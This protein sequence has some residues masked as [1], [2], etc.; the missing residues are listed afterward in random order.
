RV[1][2]RKGDK[3]L[4]K[5][6]ADRVGVAAASRTDN[7]QAKRA[8]L[9][10]QLSAARECGDELLAKARYAIQERPQVAVWNA[11]HTRCAPRNGSHNY[12]S[13]SQQ[14]DVARKLARAVTD[15]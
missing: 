10:Q 6:L 8:H 2:P 4:I 3:V 5:K 1:E 7:A 15:D 11:Q 12:G 13:A 14:V 9:R